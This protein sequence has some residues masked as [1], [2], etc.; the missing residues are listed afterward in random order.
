L[1][2]AS[3]SVEDPPAF[4]AAVDTAFILGLGKVGSTVKILLDI[5]RVL[6]TP[7]ID[8]AKSAAEAAA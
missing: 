2:V 3:D 8:A 7:E 5:D 4:G 1:D 6:T